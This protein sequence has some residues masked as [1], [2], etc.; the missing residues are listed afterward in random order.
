MIINTCMYE[1]L[2]HVEC[3]EVLM[4]LETVGVLICDILFKHVHIHDKR[5]SNVL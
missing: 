5:V 1:E 3:P 2:D 4:A